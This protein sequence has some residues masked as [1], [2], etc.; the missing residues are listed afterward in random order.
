MWYRCVPWAE[1]RHR[2]PH[3]LVPLLSL[4]GWIGPVLRVGRASPNDRVFIKDPPVGEESGDVV[5]VAEDGLVG[6]V[7]VVLVGQPK[8][9]RQGISRG[10]RTRVIASGAGY[11]NFPAGI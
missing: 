11:L 6:D 4:R 9:L 1:G 2:V 5:G 8:R 3:R 7:V 10:E